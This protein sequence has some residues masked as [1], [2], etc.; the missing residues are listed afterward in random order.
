M[1]PFWGVLFWR[2]RQRRR[3]AEAP[4]GL[5][6]SSEAAAAAEAQAAAEVAAGS[7]AAAGECGGRGITGHGWEGGSEGG[8]GGRREAP[9][10]GSGPGGRGAQGRPG[11][12]ALRSPRPGGRSAVSF[13][14]SGCS[15]PRVPQLLPG[16]CPRGQGDPPSSWPR[17]L[18]LRPLRSPPGPE[19]FIPCPGVGPSS[20]FPAAL[21]DPGCLP[22]TPLPCS[23]RPTC[24]WSSLLGGP[25]IPSLWR[26][27]LLLGSLPSPFSSPQIRKGLGS[28][29]P[30]IRCSPSHGLQAGLESHPGARSTVKALLLGTWF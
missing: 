21:P 29:S 13:S 14:V 27:A 4:P 5:G 3:D 1:P 9:R 19:A 17:S 16:A 24:S 12:A 2:Q 6:L 28:P 8:K 20:F 15:A 30:H 26:A 7:G 18:S 23:Y 25:R 22:E 10:G 11:T